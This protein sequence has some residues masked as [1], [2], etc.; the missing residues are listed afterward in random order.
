MVHLRTTANFFDFKKQ[1]QRLLQEAYADDTGGDFGE[2]E[3]GK[4]RG[5]G[6]HKAG[7]LGLPEELSE[8]IILRD[9]L[10]C[11]ASVYFVFK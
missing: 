11:M 4:Y 5:I 1:M 7:V 6:G 8:A 3:R 9:F 2:G 10:S